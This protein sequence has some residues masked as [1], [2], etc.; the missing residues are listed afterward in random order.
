MMSYVHLC[1][2]Y[3]STYTIADF[4]N[5]KEGH[6]HNAQADQHLICLQIT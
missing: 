2:L 5:G 4:A 1:S 6:D 3:F